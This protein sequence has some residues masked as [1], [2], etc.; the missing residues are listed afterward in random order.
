MRPP[1]VRRAVRDMAPYAPPEDLEAI[2]LRTGIALRALIKL[3]ANENPYGPSPRVA[4]A[5]ARFDQYHRYPDPDQKV[6][7]PLVAAY[8]GVPADSV[9]LGNGSDE[10]IDLLCRIYL[11][12]DDEVID[13][14]PTFGMYVFSTALCGGRQVEVPRTASW[15]VDFD[16]VLSAITPRTRLIFLA[17]PNNPTGNALD[18]ESVSAL[19][20][21]GPVV[22]LDEAYV[23]FSALP[24]FA[25]MVQEYDNLVVLRTFSKWSGLAG[26]RVCYGVLPPGIAQHLWKI[27]PPF[28]VNLAAEAAVRATLEDLQGVRESIAKI[29]DERERMAELLGAIDGMRVWPSVANFLLVEVMSG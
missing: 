21:A 2:G 4:E 6:I 20:R 23:E 3:D 11:E 10:I 14:T 19:L 18:R 25:P 17:T 16:A 15:D 22:V 24:S 9:M 12:P 29:V 7:R 28:N 26:L 13:C 8:A 1:S 27:K 5:L